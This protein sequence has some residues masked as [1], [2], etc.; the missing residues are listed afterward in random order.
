MDRMIAESVDVCEKYRKQGFAC[1]ESVCRALNDLYQLN[2]SEDAYRVMSV[3]AG[4][5]IADGR[6]G[7]VEAGMLA[8][9]I[10][11]KRGTFDKTVSLDGLS[12]KLHQQFLEYYGGYHCKD[13]F[14]PLYKKHKESGKD[15]AD[16]FCAFHDGIM[17][18]TKFI[19]QNM[20]E[21]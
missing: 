13:I 6:C 9:T 8:L 17:L 2:L 10:L 14:Y 15:E 4:G 19:E 7:V 1:S 21:L 18:V 3:F 12:V 5:G 11:Y 16:F 20:G